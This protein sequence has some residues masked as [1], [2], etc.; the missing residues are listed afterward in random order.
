MNKHGNIVEQNC[1]SELILFAN[2]KH[3]MARTLDMLKALKVGVNE[4]TFCEQEL[5]MSSHEA[6]REDRLSQM[7]KGNDALFN[8]CGL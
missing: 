6:N 2:N 7:L 3:S 5:N 8:T 1:Y 4:N